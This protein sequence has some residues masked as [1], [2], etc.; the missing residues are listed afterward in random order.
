MAE[1]GYKLLEATER[2]N[3]LPHEF[4]AAPSLREAVAAVVGR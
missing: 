3:Q 1:R 4:W 2:T